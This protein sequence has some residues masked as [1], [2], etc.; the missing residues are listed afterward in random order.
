MSQVADGVFTP[1]I[2][3]LS[4]K[5]NTRCGKRMPWLFPSISLELISWNRYYFGFVLVVVS[6][7]FV[8]HPCPFCEGCGT[9]STLYYLF[10]PVLFSI[11]WVAC[12][13]SHTTL[14]RSMTISKVRRENLMHLK[15]IFTYIAYLCVF[16]FG[17]V[18]FAS[19]EEEPRKYQI[20]TEGSL[21]IGALASLF[22]MINIP[23]QK[24][25]AACRLIAQE[26][27][28]MRKTQMSIPK[29][30]MEPSKYTPDVTPRSMSGGV[31]DFQSPGKEEGK[32][33]PLPLQGNPSYHWSQ[34]LVDPKFYLYG[35]AYAG[36]RIY[37]TISAVM[38]FFMLNDLL[39][40]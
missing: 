38:S 16:T 40:Y 8:F 27:K 13:A 36:A 3:H 22:F 2:R 29:S 6:F 7:Y 37:C 28:N 23:E 11:G 35:I 33:M 24:L 30:M 39:I 12:N 19:L 18:L 10:P 26:Y 21:I 1:V 25:A 15:D 9:L 17:F 32:D 31:P 4:E 34:W 5:Y 20:L 14:V